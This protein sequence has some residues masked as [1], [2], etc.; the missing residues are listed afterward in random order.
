MSSIADQLV[1]GIYAADYF[2]LR[3]VDQIKYPDEFWW[4]SRE[5]LAPA[6]EYLEIDLGRTRQ[7]NYLKFQVIRAPID[8]TISYDK[9]SNDDGSHQWEVV[10]PVA[11][12]RFDDTI[13]YSP[14]HRTLW[15]EA[16]FYLADLQGNTINT[17]FIRIKFQRR[18][19]DWPFRGAPKIKWSVMVKNLRT[20]RFVASYADTLG[21]FY[22]TGAG[23]DDPNRRRLMAITADQYEDPTVRESD[24]VVQQFGL[25][26]DAARG[27]AI[28]V[29]ESGVVDH[30]NTDQLIWPQLMGFSILG[31]IEPGSDPNDVVLEYELLVDGVSKITGLVKGATGTGRTWINAYFDPAQAIPTEPEIVKIVNGQPY[32]DSIYTLR[33]KSHSVHNNRG[34][35]VFG[36]VIDGSQNIP[37][38][39]LPG[40]INVVNNSGTMEFDTPDHDFRADL[41]SGDVIQQ[42]NRGDIAYRVADVTSS[43]ILIADPITV[44]PTQNNLNF[45][46]ILPLQYGSDDPQL[47][48]SLMIRLW[49]DVLDQGRDVLGNFFRY[50]VHL[51][52]P[53]FVL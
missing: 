37:G 8:I 46:K 34:D 14:A 30:Y 28:A 20:S 21:T 53:E 39:P 33:I 31:Y 52:R 11:N 25:P 41:V 42:V 50:G 3:G 40:S 26:N 18:D 15:H 29:V 4:A 5:R 23:D 1:N 7:V 9:I 13:H 45:M 47:D 2:Q 49:A 51:D 44:R 36:K 27:N 43:Q 12:E 32:S 17:R 24:W 10:T 19:E 16:E 22:D 35:K 38:V 6:A 48:R